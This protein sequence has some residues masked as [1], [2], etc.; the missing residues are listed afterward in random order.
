MIRQLILALLLALVLVAAVAAQEQPIT[1]TID[2]LRVRVGPGTENV[3]ISRIPARSEV[4]VEARNVVGNWTLVHT[5]DGAIRG[6]VASRYLIWT[7]DLVLE[8]LPVSDEII[9]SEQSALMVRLNDTPVVPVATGR[10]REIFQYGLSLGNHP[11]RFSKVGDCQS[12]SGYFLGPY[13]QGTYNLGEYGHLQ[14]TIDQ[15]AGSFA[16]D[17][18]SVFSGFIIHSVLDPTWANPAQCE[19]GETPQE[20]EYRLWQPSFVLISMETTYGITPEGYEQSLRQILDFWISKGVVPIVG[21]KADNREGDWSVNAVIAR[22]AWEYDVPLWNFL[23]ATQPLPMEGVYDGFHLTYAPPY[24]NNPDN[25]Q[26]AWPW[27]N[28]TALQTLDSVWRGV[29]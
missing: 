22:V 23:M 16:R 9:P 1:R 3:Q 8:T 25:M 14:A 24:F 11:D 18:L 4:V 17:S 20:C 27:R 29:G 2:N 19:P 15:F 12:V 21:T 26:S 7:D 28:L 5:P 10:A 6:W 13:D